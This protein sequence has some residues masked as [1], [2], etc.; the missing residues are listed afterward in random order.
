MYY[1]HLFLVVGPIAISIVPYIILSP[2]A[3]QIIHI[4]IFSFTYIVAK[5]NNHL[6]QHGYLAKAENSVDLNVILAG[7]GTRDHPPEELDLDRS[8]LEWYRS[9]G[10]GS[11]S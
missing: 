5:S 10:S 8:S 2:S 4:T 1:L 3:L 7:S 11:T 6:E 9:T